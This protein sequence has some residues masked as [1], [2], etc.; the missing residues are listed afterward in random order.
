DLLER[1]TWFDVVGHGYEVPAD[2]F[3]MRGF[4]ATP[5]R[6][7]IHR[8]LLTRTNIAQRVGRLTGS[9]LFAESQRF[10]E[11]VTWR[12]APVVGCDSTHNAVHNGR[13]FWIWGDTSVAHYPLGI[14]H[15]TAATTDVVPPLP[16]TPP[17]KLSYEYFLDADERARGVAPLPGDGPTWLTAL[18]SLP[19]RDG[20]S[21]LVAS[22]MKIRGTLEAYERGLC[23]W[24]DEQQVFSRHR[25]VWRRDGSPQ[26]SP[27]IPDGHASHWRDEE[28]HDWVLFGNPLPTVRCRATYEA[29]QDPNQWEA[30]PADD[31]L[32]STDG[33]AVVPH[34]GSLAWHPWRQRWTIVFVEKFGK[35]SAFGEVWYA[36][37]RS[38]LGPW[39]PAVKILTH[40]NYTFYNPK[41]HAT[42]A[43][44]D[45]P[46]L[47]FEGTYTAQF[48]NRPAPT[49]RYDYNQILYRLDLDDPRL[50]A[51]WRE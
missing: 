35:P 42:F 18:V 12:D 33:V 4:R 11:H 21:H 7:E 45:S 5:R 40:Q 16:L 2:G 9:G 17:L 1:E 39:G 27:P 14:F 50:K 26:E 8:V 30:L 6:G 19:D 51:A 10:G 32:T 34:S 36:E 20:K 3:G 23:V 31:Q 25:V 13:L 47:Y 48:A 22:Y 41:Q 29:W 44:A 38:P 15:A 37:A 43:R 28:G 49:P 46:H 24:D